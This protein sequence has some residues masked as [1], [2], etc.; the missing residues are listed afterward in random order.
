[1]NLFDLKGLD[2][3]LFNHLSE[4]QVMANRKKEIDD[5]NLDPQAKQ[6]L[7]STVTTNKVCYFI[8]NLLI[9]S[10]HIDGSKTRRSLLLLPL[11]DG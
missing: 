6:R 1:M 11:S 5:M 10:F 2:T 7:L 4:L 8:T 3:F 9:H